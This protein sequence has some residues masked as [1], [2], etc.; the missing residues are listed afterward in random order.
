MGTI[1]ASAIIASARV[2]LLDPAPGTT[3]VDATLL[4]MLNQA[5]RAAC[6]LRGDLF[7]VR[8]AITMVAG[9]LQALPAGGTGLIKLDRNVVS[10]R[11]CRLVDSA[12]LDAA[13]RSWPAAT[14]AV[15]VQ[16]YTTDPRDPK[17]FHVTPPNTGAGSVVALYT[18]VPTAIAIVGNVITLDDIY[19][20][21]LQHFVIGEAY[22]A[23]TKRQDLTKAS[24]YRQSFEK[25]L[26]MGAQTQTAVAP[27]YGATPGGA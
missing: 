14:A 15:D 10:G 21:A 27:K 4:A 24:F 1:L 2:T 6:A 8:A 13:D 22:S 3:W 17:R 19:E 23:N 20:L 25:Q 11:R 18:A 12:M 5:Q 26:G 7:T 9:T 16:E